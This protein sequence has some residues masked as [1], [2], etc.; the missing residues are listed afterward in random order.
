MTRR[1]LIILMSALAAA[2]CMKNFDPATESETDH[3]YIAVDVMP[4]TSGLPYYDTD[5]L[6]AG[7]MLPEEYRDMAKMRITVYCYDNEGNFVEKQIVRCSSFKDKT[8]FRFS[9]L[10]KEDQYIFLATAEF[11]RAAE[12]GGE[13]DTWYPMLQGTLESFHFERNYGPGGMFDFIC[14]ASD[15]AFPEGQVIDLELEH[16]GTYCYLIYEQCE[17]VEEIYSEYTGMYVF[18]PTGND[19]YYT[20]AR[21]YETSYFEEDE[22]Y[23]SHRSQYIIPTAEGTTEMSFRFKYH[24]PAKAPLECSKSIN[25]ADKVPLQIRINCQS[26]EITCTEQPS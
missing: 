2:S 24:D 5:D 13:T 10:L 6:M 8:T 25:I 3:V 1:I 9:H 12:A 23:S 14:C 20:V 15:I 26:G 18:S 19:E 16:L 4:A 22:Y 17:N 11:F 21:F 7:G